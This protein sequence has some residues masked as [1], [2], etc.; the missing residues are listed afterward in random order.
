M[1]HEQP[2]RQVFRRCVRA[3]NPTV[4]ARRLQRRP[5]S[6]RSCGFSILSAAPR[7]SSWESSSSPSTPNC[8]SL[9]ATV[10]AL[11]SLF[12][13]TTF[14]HPMRNRKPRTVSAICALT[15]TANMTFSVDTMLFSSFV[16]FVCMRSKVNGLLLLFSCPCM[17]GA[18]NLTA[19]QSDRRSN[20]TKQVEQKSP[21]TLSSERLFTCSL[22]VH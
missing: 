8:T 7:C 11:L 21:L 2:S 5:C 18:K 6:G 15:R 13:R 14:Q 12:A 10:S 9:G 1:S 20:E 17:G 3:Q 19:S 4:S 16:L 22:H